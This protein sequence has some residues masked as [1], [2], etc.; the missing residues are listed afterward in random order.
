MT[1]FNQTLSTLIDVPP[2]ATHIYLA[3]NGKSKHDYKTRP[4]FFL[5]CE[6]ALSLCTSVWDPLVARRNCCALVIS[7][8]LSFVD[9]ALSLFNLVRPC[10]RILQYRGFF[11]FLFFFS[12]LYVCCALSYCTALEII[13][14]QE[15]FSLAEAQAS[16]LIFSKTSNLLSDTHAS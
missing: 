13:S 12:L 14:G 10:P 1:W 11:L 7:A 6:K 9:N 3:S 4:R 16:N 5:S 15:L 8:T 2:I